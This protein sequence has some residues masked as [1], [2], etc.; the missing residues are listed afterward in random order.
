M[1]D[2]EWLNWNRSWRNSFFLSE[3]FVH[4]KMLVFSI[5]SRNFKRIPHELAKH[6]YR[7]SLWHC[8]LFIF[9]VISLTC[10]ILILCINKKQIQC[11]DVVLEDADVVKAIIEYINR[12]AIEVLILG[13]AAK[14]GL[15]RYDSFYALKFFLVWDGG[16]SRYDVFVEC[17]QLPRWVTCYYWIVIVLVNLKLYLLPD[18]CDVK[19]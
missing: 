15:L 2:Q 14:G 7:I 5:Q 10:L 3:Y 12:T 17:R 13:A 19:K 1:M 4:V 6:S 9:V 16:S 11:Y 18:H 8:K